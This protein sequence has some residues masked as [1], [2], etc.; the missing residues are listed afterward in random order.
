MVSNVAGP[1]FG[2]IERFIIAA[3]VSVAAL[4]YYSVPFDLVTK[5]LIFPAS[6]AP[7]LFPY[8]QLSTEAAVSEVSAVTS[9][10]VKYLLLLMTPVTAIFCV[11][12]KDILR[13]WMGP[14]FAVAKRRS[15]AT[16]G[17]SVVS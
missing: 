10:S 12:A 16:G 5:V 13:L 3:V 6:I 1:M 4:T 14:Q 11:F 15:D 7:A 2:S 17:S 8:F 9:K